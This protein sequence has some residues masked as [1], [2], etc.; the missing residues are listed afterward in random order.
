MAKLRK[1]MEN[2]ANEYDSI[3]YFWCWFDQTGL[4]VEPNTLMNVIL[5]EDKIVI[6]DENHEFVIKKEKVKNITVSREA[7]T[8]INEG[9]EVINHYIY[10]INILYTNSSEIESTINLQYLDY[11]RDFKKYNEFN[12][13][14][15]AVGRFN[16]KGGDI[17]RGTIEL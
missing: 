4:P 5:C 11:N 9:K 16:W 10:T 6:V 13:F 14:Q 3:G 8:R 2:R 15:K 17:P 7:K 12:L 1:E